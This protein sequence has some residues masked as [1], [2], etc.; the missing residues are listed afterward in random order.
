MKTEAITTQFLMKET[1]KHSGKVCTTF[2][3]VWQ[4][5]SPPPNFLFGVL[6]ESSLLLPADDLV[7]KR[8]KASRVSLFKNNNKKK[9]SIQF[10]I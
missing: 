9:I 7:S 5:S 2:D 6:E 4:F 1:Y 8:E 10:V 3:L